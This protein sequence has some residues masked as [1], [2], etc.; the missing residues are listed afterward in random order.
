MPKIDI[1]RSEADAFDVLVFSESWLK[2]NI[3]DETIQIEN[4]KSPY[5][6]DRVDRIGGEVALYV[7]NTIPCKRRI[8]LEVLD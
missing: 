6:K 3:T 4:F 5:M 8:D 1:I 2:P 7:R